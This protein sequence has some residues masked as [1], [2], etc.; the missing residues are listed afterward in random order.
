[1]RRR[2]RRAVPEWED[3]GEGVTVTE[4]ERDGDGDVVEVEQGVKVGE[5][6][7]DR[8]PLGEIEEVVVEVRVTPPPE[9]PVGDIT[10]EG[11]TPPP[12]PPPT[13]PPPPPPGERVVDGEG[14]RGVAE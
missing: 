4:G 13:P 14:I 3:L 8:V 2:T 5:G 10:G 12:L 11:V 9:S 6:V 7:A 1:M